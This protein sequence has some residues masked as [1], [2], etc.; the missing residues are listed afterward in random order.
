MFLWSVY[1]AWYT[2]RPDGPRAEFASFLAPELRDSVH[3]AFEAGIKS[4]QSLAER[5]AWIALAGLLSYLG[6]PLSQR[7][8]RVWLRDLPAFQT[9]LAAA[10]EKSF[11]VGSFFLIG[12]EGIFGDRTRVAPFTWQKL[13]LKA[14]EEL[15][16][17]PA[18]DALGTFARARSR[19]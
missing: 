18:L 11:L 9:L 3:R 2:W 6:V 4:K 5:D 16:E 12:L 13:L 10:L 1:N 19:R 7:A 8:R 15:V 14:F 17:S